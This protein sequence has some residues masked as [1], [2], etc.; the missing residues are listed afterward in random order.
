MVHICVCV[1]FHIL[2]PMERWV[3]YKYD[4][5]LLSENAVF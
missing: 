2:F 1:C 5:E 3:L 4:Y